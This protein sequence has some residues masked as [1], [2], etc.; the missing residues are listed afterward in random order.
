MARRQ[1]LPNFVAL[2]QKACEV[3]AVGKFCYRKSRPKISRF[4]TN[5]QPG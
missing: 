3:S 5:R 1:T 4:V 2:R